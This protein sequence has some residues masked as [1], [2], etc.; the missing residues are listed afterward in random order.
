MGAM[1][2]E[3]LGIIKYG[4]ELMLDRLYAR[5]EKADHFQ[6]FRTVVPD[7]MRRTLGTED[8][9][10]GYNIVNI[11]LDFELTGPRHDISRNFARRV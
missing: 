11:V 8:Y 4:V 5:R 3:E 1:T 6:F 7:H 2:S 9:G 10:A